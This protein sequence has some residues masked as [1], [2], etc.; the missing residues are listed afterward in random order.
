[1]P[2]WLA[3]SAFTGRAIGGSGIA[4]SDRAIAP[5]AAALRLLAEVVMVHAAPHR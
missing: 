3:R 2:G 1:M 5:G 4:P